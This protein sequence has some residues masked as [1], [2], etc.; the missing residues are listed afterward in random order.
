MLVSVVDSV[1][2]IL[3]IL[4]WSDFVQYWFVGM[5]CKEL[6]IGFWV[7][8]HPLPQSGMLNLIYCSTFW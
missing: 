2:H 5:T 8:K 3:H 6:S 1:E 7:L 4:N